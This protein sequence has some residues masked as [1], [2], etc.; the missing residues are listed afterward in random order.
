MIKQTIT[1]VV[2]TGMLCVSSVSA[3]SSVCENDENRSHNGQPSI[4]SKPLF[5]GHW[6]ASEKSPLELSMSPGKLERTPAP[7]VTVRNMHFT[8]Q[9]NVLTTVTKGMFAI[10]AAF[11]L[12]P[13]ANSA[14]AH[15]QQEPLV[16]IVKTKKFSVLSLRENVAT[17]V[18]VDT[19]IELPGG[20]YHREA[21][22]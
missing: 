16:E 1:A 7:D 20:F 13:R 21:Y 15:Q 9:G 18:A 10:D 11:M 12:R 14:T 5:S 3:S 17:T 4:G 2:F 6:N 8:P 22:A 19:D